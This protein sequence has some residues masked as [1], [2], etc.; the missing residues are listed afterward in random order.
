MWFLSIIPKQCYGELL[1]LPSLATLKHL[2]ILTKA[3]WRSVNDN[4]DL[5]WSLH[6]ERVNWDFVIDHSLSIY[7]VL[8]FY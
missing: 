8:I 5:W 7:N 6:F 1:E 4:E 3:G 2:E